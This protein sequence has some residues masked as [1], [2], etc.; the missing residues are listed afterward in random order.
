MLM[1]Y[2]LCPEEVVKVKRLGEKFA[3]DGLFGWLVGWL[4]IFICFVS[5]G[6]PGRVRG[7]DHVTIE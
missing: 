6:W 5:F 7:V 1:S 4:D 3:K 2:L